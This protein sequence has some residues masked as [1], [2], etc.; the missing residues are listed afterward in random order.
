MNKQALAKY[1]LDE[2]LGKSGILLLSEKKTKCLNN[3]KRNFKPI[4]CEKT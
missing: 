1:F 3:P 4:M 2:N